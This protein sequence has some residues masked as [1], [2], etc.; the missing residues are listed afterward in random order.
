MSVQDVRDYLSQWRLQ[1]KV[2]EFEASSATVDLA[3][4]AIGT[5][6]ARIAKSLTFRGE[7]TPILVV[8]AGDTKIDNSKF[9]KTFG[10]KARM[11]SAEE[12][13]EHTGH[14]VG[15]VCPFA[16]KGDIK[17]YL[18]ESMKRFETIYPACGSSH[19]CIQ[20]TIEE[21]E[22]TTPYENWVDVC[23]IKE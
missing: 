20:M 17:V 11:L 10:H 13:L 14:A 9:K 18:D 12:V 2:L 5:Q 1:D 3:A 19:S 8:A 7:E 22:T 15:G 6:P 4:Q 16:L 23:K 21:L